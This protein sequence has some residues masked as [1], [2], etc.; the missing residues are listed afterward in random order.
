MNLSAELFSAGWHWFALVLSAA[1]GWL[2]WRTAPWKRL[3][4]GTQSNLLLGFAV[5]LMLMWSLKAGVKPGLNLHLMGAMAATLALGPQLAIVTLGLALT[6]IAF[7]GAIEWQAWPINFL[8]MVVVPVVLAHR[9]HRLIE[10]FLPAHFFVFV[11]VAGFFGAA[12]TV[13]LQ[14]L[15]ASGVMVMAGAYEAAFLASDYLPYF[16]LLGFSEGWISG[17]VITLMVV[18]RPEWVAAFDDRRYL[19]GK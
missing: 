10:R 14:G 19:A 1:V 13:M 6:G 7:N 18:Y 9:I 2:V 8:L 15:V 17:G 5:G 11:F 12:L 16:L 4:S 3:G